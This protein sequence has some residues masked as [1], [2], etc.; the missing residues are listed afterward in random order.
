MGMTRLLGCMVGYGLGTSYSLSLP[1][2]VWL[3][4]LYGGYLL[5]TQTIVK[6]YNLN[7]HF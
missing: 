7:N 6:K 3:Y 5:K 2:V 1:G 4:G